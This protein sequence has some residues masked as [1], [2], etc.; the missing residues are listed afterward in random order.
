M[1][2]TF[3]SLVSSGQIKGSLFGGKSEMSAVFVPAIY[4]KAQEQYV[5]S[6]FKQNG[7][8][9]YSRLKKIGITEP[10]EYVRHLFKDQQIEYLSSSCFADYYLHQMGED[11]EEVL[12][13]EGY[14]D[15]SQVL[16]SILKEGDVN[17]MATYYNKKFV[18]TSIL[19][20]TYLFNNTFMKKFTSNFQKKMEKK[21]D[22]VLKEPQIVLAFRAERAVLANTQLEDEHVEEKKKSKGSKANKKKGATT[23]ENL[24]EI[25][26]IDKATLEQELS[27]EIED[28]S[29]EL[30]EALVDIFLRSL[31]QQFFELL[32]SNIEKGLISSS[33]SAEANQSPSKSKRTTMK[34][35]QEKIRM[36]LLSAKIFEKGVNSF[37]GNIWNF[38]GFRV[39]Y[40]A[41]H[42]TLYFL[43]TKTQ[44]ALRQHL[45]KTVYSDIVNDM[46]KFIANENAIA[47]EEENFNTEV[48]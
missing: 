9:D 14:C 34:E 47:Y 39:L 6:F 36:F 24:V 15:L 40:E 11:I 37:E 7:Y 19:A 44:N 32:K 26:F 23:K 35:M 33:A 46:F 5:M 20:D 45:I 43:D 22:E 12:N 2:E 31:N 1:K 4:I 42:I 25:S 41:N 29:E 18:E 13:K 28:I 21:A 10:D 48:I 38:I 8:I 3:D 27:A 17:K 16:P 30:L